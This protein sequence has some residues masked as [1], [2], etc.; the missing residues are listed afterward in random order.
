MTVC[1]KMHS[2]SFWLIISLWITM[3]NKILNLSFIDK[4]KI[5][6]KLRDLKY[7]KKHIK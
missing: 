5:I 2:L 4:T 7:L 6:K 3:F 1:F